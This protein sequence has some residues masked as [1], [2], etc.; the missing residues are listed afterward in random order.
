MFKTANLQNIIYT[1]MADN[2]NVTVNNL[3]LYVPNLI[4]SV[5]TQLMFDEPTK[6]SYKIS[7]DNWYTERRLLSDLLVQL[8]IGS[9]QQVNSPNYLIS[10][11]QTSLRTT[12]PDEKI[13]MAIFDNL[14]LRKYYVEIDSQRYPGDSVLINYEE[15]DYIQ[16]HKDIKLFFRE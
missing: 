9:A 12:T 10:A 11:R 4:P 15:N 2:I 14:V 8:D 7:F 5:E 6:I 3:Y 16:Q 13:H 1:S